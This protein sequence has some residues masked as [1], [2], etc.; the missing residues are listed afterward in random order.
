MSN[1]AHLNVFY[2]DVKA[3]TQTLTKQQ[4][5]NK[6]RILF[7][8]VQGKLYTLLMSDPDAPAKSWLHWLIT[9]ISGSIPDI[10]EGDEIISYAPPTPP[11][12]THRYIFTLYEQPASILVSAPRERGNFN[13]EAFEKQH[14]LKKILSRTVKVPAA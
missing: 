5:M 3:N 12:G 2:N 13:V 10:L 1:Q 6:P 7:K 11:S 9:N 8:G 4:T 14:G